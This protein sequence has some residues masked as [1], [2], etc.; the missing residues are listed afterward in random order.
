[1]KPTAAAPPRRRQAVRGR[2]AR[3][4]DPRPLDR[5]GDAV[6]AR[7]ASRRSS[8]L[9]VEPARAG[10]PARG[11]AAAPGRRPLRRRHRRPTSP[12][13]PST[14]RT[15]PTW[16]TSTT[17]GVVAG[18][19]R[20]GRGGDHG[21]VRR[22]GR[23]SPG[24]R[25]RSAADVPTWEPPPSRN[26]IDPLRLRASS[27]SWASP[28]SPPCTDAEFA[29]RSSLDIC[30]VLPDARRG[31]RVRG[32]TPTPRSGPKWVD[33]LLD[34]PEYADLFAMKW[35]AILRNKRTLGRALAAGDVRLPRLDPPVA[36]REHALRPV[37]RRDPRRP[38][39]RRVN[40]P[41]VW[42]R[43]VEHGRG[44]G[45][46]HRAAL[47]RPPDPVRPVPPPPVRALGP[48][49]LLRLRLVLHPDRPQAGRRPGHAPDLRPARRAWPTD[50]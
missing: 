34:R 19:R 41:V 8:G 18:A 4:P 28:P 12:G 47:P 2:L 10:R 38:G 44:A 50:P 31:R 20:R 7:R 42:Y 15:P 46:R 6:R 13:W 43:Q 48:G 36:R 17:A 39:R 23:A 22:A 26:L 16:P 14:S 29:R 27:E 32:A 30:G 25:S 45:R 35:S 40:P 5:P 9:D 3:V 49:R 21:P 11:P 37:R 33:R 24:S 1:M